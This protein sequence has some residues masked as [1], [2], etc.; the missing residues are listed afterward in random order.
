MP[1][2]PMVRDRLDN[3]KDLLH[4][5]EANASRFDLAAPRPTADD[6][7]ACDQ[8][9]RRRHGAARADAPRLRRGPRPLVDHD[10]AALRHR[11]GRRPRAGCRPT[12]RHGAVPDGRHVLG[13]GW[14]AAMLRRACLRRPAVG[15]VRASS[16][17]SRSARSSPTRPGSRSCRRSPSP[18]RS[19]A[20]VGASQALT[21]RRSGRRPRCRGRA[22]R[23]VRLRRSAAGRRRHVRGARR[24]GT[25]DPG[26]PRAE[27]ARRRCRGR[28]S[29]P[30]RS[31]SAATRSSGRSLLGI[32][33]LVLVGE[34]DERGRGLPRCAGRSARA[35]SRSGWSR[36]RSPPGSSP[37]RWSPA[38]RP[39]RRPRRAHRGGRARPRL[40]PRAWPDSP[41]RSGCSPGAWAF[42]GV[43]NGFA[44]VDASTLLLGRTPD[45]C[46][47]RVLA[48]V[49]AMV[50]GSSLVAMLL[51][52][53]GRHAARP[54]RDIRRRRR[55]DGGR[56]RR[57]ARSPHQ[58]AFRWLRA[59]RRHSFR[60]SER[61]R[62][63]CLTSSQRSSFCSFLQLS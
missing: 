47:G 50:R 54:T 40:D 36:R 11:P 23:R 52:G 39:G 16:S 29:R 42:L 5:P 49:N 57:P 30:N 7:G 46:R 32:C 62:A 22:G 6:P 12:G 13:R 19:A 44:N 20:A 37:A 31:R 17:S 38:G 63:S 4:N 8:R 1:S 35:T 61:S 59:K 26:D 21:T 18:T 51:G 48:T 25:G 55:P 58:D 28:S 60:A 27:A 34:V 45:F 41:P 53:V 14:Q 9:L 2:L 15:R 10:P 43:S 33:A 3:V 56:R 24:G